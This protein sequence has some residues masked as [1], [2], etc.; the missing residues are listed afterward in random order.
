MMTGCLL[1][2]CSAL[3]GLGAKEAP[4]PAASSTPKPSPPVSAQETASVIEDY[5][6]RNNVANAAMSDK[7]LA[8]YEGGSSLA[9]DKA[10]YASG[11]KLGEDPGRGRSATTSS[12]RTTGCCPASTTS[13]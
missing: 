5:I 7:L 3:P 4:V 9:I 1:A 13:P 6:E 8:G 12:S 10:S 2:G 11:R